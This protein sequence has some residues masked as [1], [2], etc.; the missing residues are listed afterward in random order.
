MDLSISSV[1]CSRMAGLLQGRDLTW[2]N[3]GCYSAELCNIVGFRWLSASFVSDGEYYAVDCLNEMMSR[4][5]QSLRATIGDRTFPAAAASVWN[6]PPESVRASPSLQVF[7]SRLKTR[8]FCPVVQLLW[9]RASHCTDYHVTSLLFLRVTCPCSLRT[10]ATLKFIRSSS[11]SSSSKPPTKSYKYAITHQFW[12]SRMHTGCACRREFS[13][14]LPFS[15]TKSST[16]SRRNTSVH[17]TTS[18]TCLAADLS[19]LL[20]LTVWQCRQLSWQPSPTNRA[21]TWNDMPDGVTSAESLST[22]RQRLKTHLFA[23]SFSWLF[24]GLD[25]T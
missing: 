4:S 6:S 5:L 9:L 22:F 14:R 8:A 10:Y 7:R 24:P 1:T 19:V 17:S 20:A 21:F 16:H 23:K 3:K 12:H 18:P 13:K 25:F 2:F 15:S 11:S